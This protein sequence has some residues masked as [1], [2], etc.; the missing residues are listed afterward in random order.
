MNKPNK[1][2]YLNQANQNSLTLI[3]K[4]SKVVVDSANLNE[5]DTFN[6]IDATTNPSSVLASIQSK[7]NLFSLISKEKIAEIKKNHNQTEA[8][9]FIYD[10]LLIQIAEKILKKIKGFVSIEVDAQFAYDEKITFERAKRIIQMAKENGLDE[11]RILIKIASTYEGIKACKQLESEGIKCNLTLIFNLYQ[12]YFCAMQNAFT[13][14]PFVGRVLDW[15]KKSNPNADY[16]DANSEPG[17]ILVRQIYQSFKANDFKTI[18]MAAS[19]RNAGE[20]IAL[21]GCDK[22]TIAPKLLTQ[23]AELN[24]HLES[25]IDKKVPKLA[26][27]VVFSREVFNQ[28]L[29]EDLMANELLQA[30]VSG[31][32]KDTQTL[33]QMISDLI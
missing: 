2:N 16:S 18:V 30:G 17:V 13:I 20:I 19:F 23:L 33:K 15:A 28:K 12:A 8:I 5:I 9:E 14:S 26:E 6:P 24:I 29:Q 25:G 7:E 31:F 3:K 11:K 21:A 32:A 10:Y 27:K 1:T 4:L 22:L